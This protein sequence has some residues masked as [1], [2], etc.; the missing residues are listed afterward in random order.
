MY[1]IS[2]LLFF[3][4]L[5]IVLLTSLITPVTFSVTCVI[6]GTGIADCVYCFY[7]S[8]Y[9][10]SF[11]ALRLCRCVY[12]QCTCMSC[13]ISFSLI[14]RSFQFFRYQASRVPFYP[15]SSFSPASAP[16]P[17]PGLSSI[18]ASFSSSLL[19]L[20]INA[21][22]ASGSNCLWLSIAKS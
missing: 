13:L 18:S 2:R 4:V 9:G 7:I 14:F 17:N 6:N 12:Q 21:V 5:S 19:L 1:K 16:F 8:W 10:N 11:M 15:L 3:G 22:I 20:S